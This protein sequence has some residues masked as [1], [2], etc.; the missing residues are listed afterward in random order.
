MDLHITILELIKGRRDTAR[1]K[2]NGCLVGAPCSAPEATSAWHRAGMRYDVCRMS[3]GEL[4]SLAE[5]LYT[6]G[7]IS[8][9]DLRLLSLHPDTRPVHWPGWLAFETA[10][11]RDGR[12]D[13]ICEIETRIA[14]GHPDRM[15]IAYQHRFLSLLKRVEAGRNDAQSAVCASSDANTAPDAQIVRAADAP[16]FWARSAPNFG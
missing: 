8:L 9:P 15:Y 6:A 5:E 4:R 13:W 16:Q 2:T 11:G 3:K 1:R 14:K 12:R 10:G 7:A